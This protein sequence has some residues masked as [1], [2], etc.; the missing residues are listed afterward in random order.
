M[1]LNELK[2]NPEQVKGLIQLLSSLLDTEDVPVQTSSKSKN[3]NKFTS[4]PE[5]SMHKDDSDLD[6]KLHKNVA[7]IQRVREYQPVNVRCR[8]CG[9]TENINPGLVTSY[10]RYKC[11]RC[12]GTSG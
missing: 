11:N 3:N 4:M 10:D 6:K 7:P 5:F 9:K 1:D 2:N 8:I 12:S